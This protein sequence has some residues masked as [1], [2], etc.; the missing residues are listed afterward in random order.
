M[1]YRICRIPR[2]QLKMHPLEVS[3]NLRN[4][5]RLAKEH[6]AL[7]KVPVN[8]TAGLPPGAIR[9]HAPGI[10]R[11]SRHLRDFALTLSHQLLSV[12]ED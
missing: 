10:S 3:P 9:F 11:K 7:L 4:D 8:N 2:I 5:K 1:G 12:R 6:Y